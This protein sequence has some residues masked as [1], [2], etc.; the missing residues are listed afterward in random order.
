M[1]RPRGLSNRNRLQK[2]LSVAPVYEN[3]EPGTNHAALTATAWTDSSREINILRHSSTARG[4]RMS[5]I[6]YPEEMVP[7]DSSVA[8]G[9]QTKSDVTNWSDHPLGKT[10]AVHVAVSCLAKSISAVDAHDGSFFMVMVSVVTF[11]RAEV[12]LTTPE[13]Q[14]SA[15]FLVSLCVWGLTTTCCVFRASRSAGT[16]SGFRGT[17][18]RYPST[19]GRQR[20]ACRTLSWKTAGVTSTNNTCISLLTRVQ[21]LAV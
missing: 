15:Y 10:T 12:V 20:S 13:Q 3:E 6:A 9:S 11:L 1:D 19:S 4:R 16:T 17:L 21:K 14:H 7:R 5:L 18:G 8:A 2:M